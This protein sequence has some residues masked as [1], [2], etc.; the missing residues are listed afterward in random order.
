MLAT[1]ITW[2]SEKQSSVFVV[3]TANNIYKLPPEILRKGRFDEIFFIGLP[4]EKEKELIFKVH[5]SRIRPKS[6]NLYDIPYLTKLAKNFS[7]AEVEESIIEAMHIAFS[8]NREF[9][10]DDIA[11]SIQQ[12][13]PLAE[14]NYEKIDE[15]QEWADAG[16]IRLAS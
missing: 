5:L 15:L 16:K 14:L 11:S 4:N 12:F 3:A 2:L 8:E 1:F 9:T 6:W 7:G 13:I 10:T